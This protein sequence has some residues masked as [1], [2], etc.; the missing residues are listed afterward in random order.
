[1]KKIVVATMVSL[2]VA[3]S[4]MAV[5][6]YTGSLLNSVQKK[7]DAKAAPIVNQEAQIRAQQKAL[8]GFPQQQVSDKKS[9]LTA[10]QKAQQELINKKKNQIK[11]QQDLFKNEK[12]ELKSIFTI[13]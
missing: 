3:S 2:M 8:T 6:T 5:E 4:A 1:M 7:I 13:K 11:A 9:A 12:N 10:Q